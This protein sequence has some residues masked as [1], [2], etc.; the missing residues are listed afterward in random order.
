MG[1]I[2]VVGHRRPDLDSIAAALGVAALLEAEGTSARAVRPGPLDGQSEWA[3]ERFGVA[4]PELVLDV[5]PSFGAVAES[6]PTATPATSLAETVERLGLGARVVPVVGADGRPLAVIDPRAAIRMLGLAGAKVGRP[7]SEEAIRE[8]AL[9]AARGVLEGGELAGVPLRLFGA[10]ER[11]SD[12][13]ASIAREE[14]DDFAVVG[15]GGRLLGIARRA[16]ILAPPRARL[17]LVDHNELAQ[18]VPGAEEAEIVEVLDHHRLGNPPTAQPIPFVVDAVG[19]TATLVA[20]R[21]AARDRHLPPP[22]AGVLLSALLSDTLAFR[23]P[24]TTARDRA[25]AARLAERAGVA[26]LAAFGDALVAAGAGLGKLTS[27]EVVGEDWKEFETRAGRLVVSQAEVRSMNELAGR[28]GELGDAL[29]R[30]RER[31]GAAMAA[32]LLT[33]PVRGKS[34][35][36]ARGEARLLSRLPY[37]HAEDGTYDAGDVVSRKKQLVPALLAALE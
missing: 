3:L 8:G 37:P 16:S 21:W 30:L 11:I 9:R 33:D 13:R 6:I 26:D 1:V 10:S 28:T 7:G 19:S 14:A 15:E 4:A 31:R 25:I 5:A 18:A 35:L 23:S 17:F 20:E 22:L 29:E 12:H 36:I 27:D 34:R 2:T 24:T 32:L